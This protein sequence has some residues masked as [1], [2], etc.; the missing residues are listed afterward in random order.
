MARA[1]NYLC[2]KYRMSLSI[3]VSRGQVLAS[4]DLSPRIANQKQRTKGQSIHYFFPVL[5]CTKHRQQ[6]SIRL[7]VGSLSRPLA[8]GLS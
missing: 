6:L 8:L 1:L 2:R 5:S 7:G 4:G 3:S